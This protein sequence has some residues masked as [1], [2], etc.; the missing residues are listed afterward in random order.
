MI[1]KKYNAASASVTS[2]KI[3]NNQYTLWDE[4]LR[5]KYRIFLPQNMGSPM[6][7]S[8]LGLLLD[9]N[10]SE[11]S[12]NLE[13]DSSIIVSLTVATRG[14]C[15]LKPKLLEQSD[16]S[17]RF[18]SSYPALHFQEGSGTQKKAFRKSPRE[19]SK[20]RKQI[21]TLWRASRTTSQ[22]RSSRKQKDTWQSIREYS[23]ISLMEHSIEQV[24]SRAW[25][26]SEIRGM[27][28][29]GWIP[30]GLNIHNGSGTFQTT[31]SRNQRMFH[32]INSEYSFLPI[33]PNRKRGDGRGFFT[34]KKDQSNQ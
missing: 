22:K 17:R 4:T 14:E 18:D 20:C 31:C 32:R 15:T 23:R 5:G 33:F 11:H 7:R 10:C 27:I 28:Q 30:R 21:G 29:L 19:A 26:S 12:M 16:T 34:V 24:Q 8:P 25:R 2:R 13:E 1:Q 9:S 3:W 6:D